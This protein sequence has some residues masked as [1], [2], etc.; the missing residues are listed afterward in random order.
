VS[1]VSAD[2]VAR[3]LSLRLPTGR[4]IWRALES[5]MRA[6]LLGLAD[7]LARVYNRAG[8]LVNEMHPTTCIETLA[9]W[10]TEYGL[11]DDCAPDLQTVAQRRDVLL[12]K[13]RGNMSFTTS[14]VIALAASVGV[15]ITIDEPVMRR[16]GTR[17]GTRFYGLRAWNYVWIVNAPA[18]TV[19]KRHFGDRY[20]EPYA[21]WGNDLLECTL[22]GVNQAHKTLYFNYS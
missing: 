1:I 7:E 16:Y 11:P 8:D 2:D 10:E 5:N 12:A 15:A 9:D 13:Y 22:Q 14:N 20:N 3:S 6:L 18:V 19:A 17:Y 4:A 21:T